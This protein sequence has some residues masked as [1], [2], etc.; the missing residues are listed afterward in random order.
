LR[1]AGFG[2]DQGGADEQAT[3]NG[4]IDLSEIGL[5]HFLGLAEFVRLAA[6]HDTAFR[7]NIAIIGNS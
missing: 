6:Y 3:S 5:V 2:R 7:K 1:I 4:R